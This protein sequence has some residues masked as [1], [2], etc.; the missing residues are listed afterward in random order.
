MATVFKYIEW[1]KRGIEWQHSWLSCR[2]PS[3]VSK[4][5]GGF[6]GHG[7]RQLPIWGERWREWIYIFYSLF[8]A[9]RLPS[10]VASQYTTSSEGKLIIWPLLIPIIKFDIEAIKD[11]LDHLN[12][13]EFQLFIH[14]KEILS[15]NVLKEKW[16]G[17]KY[18]REPFSTN[19]LKVPIPTLLV[20]MHRP[21]GTPQ[22]P[23]S[24][25]QDRILSSPKLLG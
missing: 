11:C 13:D 21:S 17:I 14:A 20:L 1:L 8:H 24:S 7:G 12:V 19:L 5:M 4:D 10:R 18:T 22:Y 3:G 2:V 15:G 6:E 16:Y 23:T 25:C 9:A